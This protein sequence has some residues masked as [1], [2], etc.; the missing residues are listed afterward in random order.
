M[1]V[2]FRSRR[3]FAR[4]TRRRVYPCL[5]HLEARSLLSATVS[6]VLPVV[7]TA[8]VAPASVAPGAVVRTGSPDFATATPGGIGAE[9]AAQAF[10]VSLFEAISGSTGI[11]GLPGVAVTG[12]PPSI[13][14]P[15]V[16][17]MS[18]AR[19][20]FPVMFAPGAGASLPN[21]GRASAETGEINGGGTNATEDTSN[22]D[23]SQADDS[24]ARAESTPH[25]LA[26][27]GLTDTRL[28]W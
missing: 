6:V 24:Q 15:S 21:S 16:G 26:C 18:A 1:A 12:N 7:T 9:S 8:P 13:T 14:P 22:A 10:V 5:E 19:G 4:Q 27:L 11:V 28:V 20:A 2:T 3:G 17:M 23:D 25:V